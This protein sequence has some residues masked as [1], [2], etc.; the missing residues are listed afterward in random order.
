MQ[1]TTKSGNTVTVDTNSKMITLPNGETSAI[2]CV[3]AEHINFTNGRC[4]IGSVK[5]NELRTALFGW[6][7][8]SN[9]SK[10]ARYDAIMNE[11]AEGFNPYRQSSLIG[12]NIEAGE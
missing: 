8:P 11:G 10:V 1:I 5:A 6:V 12:Q 7:A 2:D 9:N 4:E 3:S